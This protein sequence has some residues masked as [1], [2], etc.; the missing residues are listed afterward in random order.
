MLGRV[1][2]AVRPLVLPKL[3]EENENSG[4]GEGGKGKGK[5]K[6]KG[7][8]KGVKDVVVTGTFDRE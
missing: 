7:K 6:V 2:E 1:V 4:V 8:R 3:R 5:G